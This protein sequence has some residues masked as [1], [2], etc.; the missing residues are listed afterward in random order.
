MPKEQT[1]SDQIVGTMREVADA[2]DIKE[3]SIA[4]WKTK[5]MPFIRLSGDRNFEYD[6]EEIYNWRVAYL[7]AMAVTNNGKKLNPVVQAAIPHMGELGAKVEEFK[8]KKADILSANQMQALAN[9]S[10][11]RKLRI[12]DATDE[13][14]LAWTVAEF[15]GVMHEEVLQ[16]AIGFDKEEIER[17]K[18][19]DGAHKILDLITKVKSW[20]NQPDG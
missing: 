19:V 7:D 3:R 1:D 16:F 17:N 9:V 2:F 12:E 4:E 18:V 10:R 6:L 8:L 15:K 11:I 5:G 20:Q 13:D 14:I